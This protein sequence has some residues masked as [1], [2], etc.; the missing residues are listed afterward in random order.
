LDVV[1]RLLIAMFALAALLIGC[2][3][4]KDDDGTTSTIK[5]GPAEEIAGTWTG[6]LSQSG[7]APFRIAVVIGADGSGEVAYTG[8]DCAGT[9]DLDS[10]E[11]PSYVFTE[12]IERGKG[13]KCKGTGTVHLRHAGSTLR[14]RFDGGGVT[15]AG[16]LV[17][18]NPR[19]LASVFSEA[20]V[21]Q[22]G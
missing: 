10:G 14:Y 12:T 2:G 20:G 22:P 7:L 6:N 8:I 1:A 17:P 11:A 18:A 13:G 16:L 3:G 21:E 15:S 19:D 4:S 9:W 5:G